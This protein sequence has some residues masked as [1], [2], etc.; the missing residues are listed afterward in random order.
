MLSMKRLFALCLV[1]GFM[2]VLAPTV[3]A[4]DVEHNAAKININTASVDQLTQLKGIGPEYAER[5]IE[6]RESHGTFKAAEDITQIPGVG[7]KTLEAN[8]DRIVIE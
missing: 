7:S 8:K 5:I 1:A 4:Q 2:V 3:W 6:F